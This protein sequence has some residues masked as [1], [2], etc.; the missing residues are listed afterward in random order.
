M[1]GDGQTQQVTNF[2]AG[3]AVPVGSRVE[4]SLHFL[5]VR[6]ILIPFSPIAV[7]FPM[8]AP[9]AAERENRNFGTFAA[10]M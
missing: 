5:R 10:T 9:H 6:T 8:S 2:D 7:R 3:P 1:P 4:W